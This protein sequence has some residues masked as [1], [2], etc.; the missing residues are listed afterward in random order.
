MDSNV[1]AIPQGMH[2]VTPHIVVRDAAR[3]AEW[4]ASALCA[5]ERD[6]LGLPDGRLLNVE[7]R[8]GDSAVRIADEFLEAGVLSPQS[9]G[10]TP[11]VLH[12][13]TD[14]VAA[15]WETIPE[16]RPIDDRLRQSEKTL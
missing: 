13:F 8:F 7:L 1:R 10:G 6:R 15:L 5:E 9:I 3:A 11:V 14:D 4:Y 2:S 16:S 12:L